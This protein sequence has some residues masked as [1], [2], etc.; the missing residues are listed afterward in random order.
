MK[1]IHMIDDYK[2]L[3]KEAESIGKFEAYK[4]YQGFL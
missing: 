1:T 4:A 3:C 2:I